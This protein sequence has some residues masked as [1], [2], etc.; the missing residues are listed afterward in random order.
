[1][2]FR[3]S[4]VPSAGAEHDRFR[5]SSIKSKISKR[6]GKPIPTDPL[7]T[8]T[9]IE[10]LYQPETTTVTPAIENVIHID[11]DA[12]PRPPPRNSSKPTIKDKPQ[13]LTD[14]KFKNNRIQKSSSKGKITDFADKTTAASVAHR[15]ISAPPSAAPKLPPK[16][17]NV[18][19]YSNLT[20]N[21]LLKYKN[22]IGSSKRV[23]TENANDEFANIRRKS[24]SLSSS[25][26]NKAQSIDE[27]SEM[28]S[29]EMTPIVDSSYCIDTTDSNC[30]VN[31]DLEQNNMMDSLSV[32]S[33]VISA[34]MM[35]PPMSPVMGRKKLQSQ[36]ST[37][38]RDSIVKLSS[39]ERKKNKKKLKLLMSDGNF[40][41][42]LSILI[43]LFFCLLKKQ[44]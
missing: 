37:S 34:S 4:Q 9:S 11:E 35:A 43:H 1:M 18:R 16:K 8:S 2:W 24:F 12:P 26:L 33:N 25:H 5:V 3:A 23:A 6:K 27:L 30:N 20:L 13:L 42:L 40:L 31:S 29:V 41:F 19:S 39:K 36:D 32:N 28:H 44:F 10:S 14:R 7:A 21:S 17:N 38:S 15:K 22:Y